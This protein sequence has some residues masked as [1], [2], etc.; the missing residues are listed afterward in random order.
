ME[1]IVLSG[2][3]LGLMQ[4]AF[5]VSCPFL[6]AADP[7]AYEV[8][9]LTRNAHSTPCLMCTSASSLA[10]RSGRSSSCR[11]RSPTCTRKSAQDG[12]TCTAWREVGLTRSVR[13]LYAV[14]D[15]H[16]FFATAQLATPARFPEG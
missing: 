13:P 10:R 8:L 16:S 4:S 12:R 5:D 15:R 1:R 14:T 9:S 6:L 7:E 11:A 2:G 3:P